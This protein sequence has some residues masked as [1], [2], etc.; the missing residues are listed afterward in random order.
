MK[1]F[2]LY[3]SENTEL[4]A[5]EALHR[6]YRQVHVLLD[7][8]VFEINVYDIVRLQQDFEI[9]MRAT[10]F[11]RIEPNIVLVESVDFR[12]IYLTVE[13]LIEQGFFRN[14]KRLEIGIIETLSLLDD[15]S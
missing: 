14:L 9:E 1:N 6:G 2:S 8:S 4:V 12:N 11:F 3:S 15:V 5:V 7:D 13:N 10:G